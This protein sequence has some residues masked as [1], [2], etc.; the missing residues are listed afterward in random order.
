MENANA[1]SHAVITELHSSLA[2]LLAGLEA[3]MVNI[4]MP[5][6]G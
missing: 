3:D 2:G 4:M 6:I 1:L 5:S